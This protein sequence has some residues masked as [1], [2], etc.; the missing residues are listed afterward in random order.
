MQAIW[1]IFFSLSFQLFAKRKEA[2]LEHLMFVRI[3]D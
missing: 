3:L 1:A 2:H